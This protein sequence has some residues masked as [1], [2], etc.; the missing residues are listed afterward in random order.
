MRETSA[1]LQRQRPARA[2]FT[3][4]ELLVVTAIIAVLAALL[5]PAIGLVRQQAHIVACQ[6]TLGQAYIG[7]ATYAEDRAGA[8]P[9][10]YLTSIKQDNYYYHSSSGG[11]NS[12]WGL[13]YTAE[14][15][16]PTNGWYCRGQTSPGFRFRTASNPWPP[17]P[18]Q[19][20]RSS[21]SIRPVMSSSTSGPLPQLSRYERKALI[22]DVSSRTD[23]IL[24]TGHRRGVNVVWGDGR[25]D[26]V[27]HS[28]Y[29]APYATMS[30]PAFSSSNNAEIDQ[31]WASFDTAYGQ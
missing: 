18:G 2:A 14:L 8:V 3:L 9:L 17:V 26:F 7:L 28:A 22:S 12:S 6:T 21:Y 31:I 4:I 23:H 15:V 16:E 11:F 20:T 30:G 1:N 5:L 29:S 19:N 25:R 27:N 24:A 13:L 10:V